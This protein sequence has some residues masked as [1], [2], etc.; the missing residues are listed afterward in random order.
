MNFKL[1]IDIYISIKGSLYLFFFGMK[2]V[3]IINK[4]Q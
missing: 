1:S 3:Q 2:P 4:I